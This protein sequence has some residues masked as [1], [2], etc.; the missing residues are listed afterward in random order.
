MRFFTPGQLETVRK[1]PSDHLFIDTNAPHQNLGEVTY[2]IPIYIGEVAAMV[3]KIRGGSVPTI[4]KVSRGNAL[5]LYGQSRG[6]GKVGA[7]SALARD[8]VGWYTDHPSKLSGGW[9]QSPARLG[10]LQPP[11]RVDTTTRH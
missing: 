11:R 9:N 10:N 2:A 1:V 6:P 4:L 3:A 5:K 7:V 8:Y